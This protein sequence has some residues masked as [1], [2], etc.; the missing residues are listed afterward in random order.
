MLINIFCE[1]DDFCK[2]LKKEFPEYLIGKGKK[3]RRS[4]LSHSEIMTIA[5]FF[6]YSGFKNFKCYY[7]QCVLKNMDNDFKQIPSYTRFIEL[8]Q[9]VAILLYLFLVLKR[10]SSCKG[11]SIIDSFPVKA[12]HV[13]RASSHK[14]NR[15]IASKGY[16]STGWF[17]GTKV[18]LII[19]LEG[20]I[21][22]FHFTKGNI[23]DSN[24]KVI[25]DI[26]KNVFGKLV[27][28]KGYIGK[29]K[30]LAKK[31]IHLIHKVRKNMKNKLL[32]MEDKLLLRKR[33]LIET[34]N[35]I[36]KEDLSIEHTRHRSTMAFFAHIFSSLVAYTF[37]NKPLNSGISMNF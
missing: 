3:N 29:A 37:R 8:K 30:M 2:Q 11:A 23:A 32:V 10:L 24:T 15:T 6:H 31:G 33:S 26:T 13:R 14:T 16:S 22:D 28:D 21:I 35:G 25:S 9:S 18:H 34:V 19:D 7:L 4:K 5:I 36:L 20:N 12:C 27:G 17:Y 1:V